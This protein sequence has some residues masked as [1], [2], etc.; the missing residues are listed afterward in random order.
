MDDRYVEK[1]QPLQAHPPH[2]LPITF[3]YHWK[4]DA[5]PHVK[6]PN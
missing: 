1:Q 3:L 2:T 6:M 5:V 4:A